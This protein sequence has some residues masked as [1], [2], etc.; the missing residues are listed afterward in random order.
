MSLTSWKKQ[1]YP[2]PADQVKSKIAAIRHS[3]RKWKGLRPKALIRHELHL[4]ESHHAVLPNEFLRNPELVTIPDEQ[5]VIDDSS[6]ALCCMANVRYTC[7][8]SPLIDHLGVSCDQ[9]GQP[10]TLFS[11]SGNPEPMIKA[12]TAVLK[13]ATKKRK[14]R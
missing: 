8:G 1:Y 5:L 7:E 2:V 10:F 12:L 9:N 13:N 4:S 3:L 14:K 11:D 6:C